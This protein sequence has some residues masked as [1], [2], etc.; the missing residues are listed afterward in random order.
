M[1][2]ISCWDDLREFGFDLLTG[3]ACGLMYRLLFDVTAQGKGILE[4]C[5]GVGLNL[6]ESW[7]RGTDEKPSV[8]SILLSN[9][10]MVPIAVFTLLESGYD[11]CW[12]C[13]KGVVAFKTTDPDTDRWKKRF[14]VQRRFSYSGTAGDRNRHEMSGRTT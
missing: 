2:L 9:E 13:E 1:K 11:E 14:N 8:G 7:N 10:M 3:E 12:I 6:S 4:K 5:F